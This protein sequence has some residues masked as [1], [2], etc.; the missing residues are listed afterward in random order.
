MIDE[1]PFGL[2]GFKLVES[3]EQ[4]M[5]AQVVRA[6]RNREPLVFVA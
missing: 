3:S 4:G 1:N 2:G 6:V 5:L